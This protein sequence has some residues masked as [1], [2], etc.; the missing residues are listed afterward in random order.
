MAAVV[1][2]NEFQ[3]AL[4]AYEDALSAA[5]A[6]GTTDYSAENAPVVSPY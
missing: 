6:Y 2:A 5:D 4:T 1:D 3:D